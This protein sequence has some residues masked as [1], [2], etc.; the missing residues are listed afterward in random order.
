MK[1][2]YDALN[3]AAVCPEE[4]APRAA[5][6]GAA[7]STAERLWPAHAQKAAPRTRTPAKKPHRHRAAMAC[8]AYG[9]ERAA[10]SAWQPCCWRRRWPAACWRPGR[11]APLYGAQ[12]L[13]PF[14]AL[15]K[16]DMPLLGGLSQGLGLTQT[17]G[18]ASITLEGVL[19]DGHCVYPVYRH[20]AAG[21]EAEKAH[22]NI[23]L[24]WLLSARMC[25]APRPSRYSPCPPGRRLKT[26]FASC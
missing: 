1:N 8:G 6:W 21:H 11:W 16:K 22:R 19:G 13:Q 23:C 18:G 12:I 14:W 5:E 24:T 9:A 3:L 4:Y 2:E 10:E 15:G 20:R 25:Q 26:S 17:V 7:K